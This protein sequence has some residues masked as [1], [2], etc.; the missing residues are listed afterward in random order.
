LPKYNSK[1]KAGTKIYHKFEEVIF[2]NHE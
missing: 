1:S 2:F